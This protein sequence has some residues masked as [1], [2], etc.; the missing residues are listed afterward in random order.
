MSMMS[1]PLSGLVLLRLVGLD[2]P[3][4]SAIAARDVLFA[5]SARMR[6]LRLACRP[7]GEVGRL[8][9]RPLVAR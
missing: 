3:S 5:M 4:S 6:S 1:Q 7:V 2:I 8:R 9:L